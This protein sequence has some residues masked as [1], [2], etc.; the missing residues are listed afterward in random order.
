MAA[1]RSAACKLSRPAPRWFLLAALALVAGLSLILVAVFIYRSWKDAK[2]SERFSE[3]EGAAD[4]AEGDGKVSERARMVF[5]Y[6]HGCT[7]CEKFEP[8][9]TEFDEKHGDRLFQLGVKL[10]KFEKSEEGAEAYMSHVKGFPTVMLAKFNEANDKDDIVVFEGE[11]T[12]DALLEFVESELGT[13]ES[14]FAADEPTEFG[15]LTNNVA[16]SKKAADSTSTG[17]QKNLQK[18]SGGKIKESGGK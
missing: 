8:V 10:A 17:K 15:T 9:W 7:W 18:N 3:G 11:R 12:P 1:K 2:N 16:K 14:F 5:M 13:K 4:G 6:M